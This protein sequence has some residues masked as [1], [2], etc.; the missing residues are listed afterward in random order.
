MHAQAL[1]FTEPAFFNI[2]SKLGPELGLL[3]FEDSEGRVHVFKEMT[4]ELGDL[5][6]K[7]LTY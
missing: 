2:C 5:S 3:G 4:V 7:P 6:L 1:I